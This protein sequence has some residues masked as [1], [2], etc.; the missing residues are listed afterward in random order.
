MISNFGSE[1]RG[2][3]GKINNFIGKQVSQYGIRQGQLDYFMMIADKPGINQLEL[4][5]MKNVGKSAVTKAIKI[6][7]ADGFV[8]RKADETDRRNVKC[9]ITDQGT[10]IL[11]QMKDVRN[12]TEQILFEGFT[13]KELEQFYGLLKKLHKNADRL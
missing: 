6:L 8:E 1:I 9:Y 11:D 4:A 3:T 12:E 7:E 2:I 13:K 5:E 10:N